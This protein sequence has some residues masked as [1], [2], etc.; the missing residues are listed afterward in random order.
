MYINPKGGL[1]MPP[2][3][4]CLGIFWA[5]FKTLDSFHWMSHETFYLLETIVD[6]SICSFLLTS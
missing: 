2:I 3:K 5:S 4:P 6:V 1:M